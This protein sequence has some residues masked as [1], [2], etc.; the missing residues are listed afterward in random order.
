MRGVEGRQPPV[1]ERVVPVHAVLHHVGEILRVDAA[2]VVHRARER[3]GQLRP[4]AVGEALLHRDLERVV[5]RFGVGHPLPDAR[6]V[7][8]AAA[9]RQVDL[10]A[11]DHGFARE[12]GVPETQQVLPPRPHVAH[13]HVPVAGKRSLH[14]RVELHDVRRL[15]VVV[16]GLELGRDARVGVEVRDHVGEGRVGDRG[17]GGEGRVE[18]AGEEVVLGQDLV[19]VQPEPGPD[20]RLAASERVPGEPQPGSEVPERGVLVP[21][22]ADG[23]L[24]VAHVAQVRDLAVRFGGGGDELVA[25]AHVGGEA[26]AE[27][28]VILEEGRE[29]PL[30]VPAVGIDLAR[31][32][33]VDAQGPALQ[34]ALQARE[35]HDAADL[36]RRVLVE[37]KVLGLDA[38]AG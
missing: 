9:A 38:G 31:D 12:V 35:V 19:I 37:L 34:E 13:R 28:E 11:V 30:A 6:E 7:R 8:V 25:Q 18:A 23:Q 10:H 3:V 24:R 14:A 26:R 20:R 33:E 1:A 4:P 21:G 29:Q 22:A 16:D 36:A 15:Q 17:P 32:R 5:E 2:R 27:A